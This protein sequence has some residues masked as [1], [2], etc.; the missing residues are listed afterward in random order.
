[1]IQL[2]ARNEPGAGGKGKGRSHFFVA[3]HVYFL[4]Y[5]FSDLFTI[6]QLCGM[7]SPTTLKLMEDLNSPVSFPFQSP[8]IQGFFSPL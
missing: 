6:T 1:M 7:S 2:T 4:A 3:L 5:I 8:K